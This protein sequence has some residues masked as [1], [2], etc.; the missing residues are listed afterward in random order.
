MPPKPK[1]TKEMILN[2][3]YELVRESGEKALN[4][5]TI[6]ERLNCSTQ[7]VL[8]YFKTMD[9]IREEVYL[10]ADEYHSEYLIQG[11]GTGNPLTAIWKNYIRFSV[12]ES[13]LFRFL[14]Q[15]NS[16]S[17]KMQGLFDDERLM[18]I[19][20]AMSSQMNMDMAKVKLFFAAVYYPIHGIASLLANNSIEANFD[21]YDSIINMISRGVLKELESSQ[22][23]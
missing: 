9:Q 23:E 15:S 18:P 12:E 16:F 2:A 3:A 21:E 4:A 7:P 6:A 8:Y 10:I 14:F 20:Y 22:K 17:G 13:Q 19:L 11:F 1:I 5:R